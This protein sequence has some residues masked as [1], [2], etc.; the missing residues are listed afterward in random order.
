MVKEKPIHIGIVYITTGIYSELWKEFYPTCECYFCPDTQKGYEVFTDSVR[1]QEMELKNVTWHP[2]KD[3]GFIRNVSAKAEFICSISA[4]LKEKYDYVFYLNGNYKFLEPIYSDEILPEA[5]HHYL[6]ALSFDTYKNKALSDLP[7]DRNPAC[8]AYIERGQGKKYYQ[9]GFY[10]GRTAEVIELSEWCMQAIRKDLENK[11]IARWHDES[12]LNRYLRDYTPRTLNDAYGYTSF[13]QSPCSY[14][15]ILIEKS[16]YL[17]DK[18][19][20]TKDL[21]VDNSL[22]FLMDAELRPQKI[23]VVRFDGGLGNQMF[24]YAYY[25]Y[26]RKELGQS[27]DFYIDRNGHT[28]LFDTFV[29]PDAIVLSDELKEQINQANPCQKQCYIEENASCFQPVVPSGTAITEYIGYWQCAAYAY[30]NRETLRKAFRFEKK[31]PGPTSL[32][33]LDRIKSTNSV[34]IH[35]RRGDYQ[36]PVNKEVYGCICTMD[37]YT[38]AIRKMKNLLPEKPFF[39]LFTDDPEWVKK[40]FQGNDYFLVEGN[41]GEDDWQDLLLMSACRH[42]I[43]AN[44]SFSWWAAWLNE[45]PDKKVLAPQWWYYGLPTPDLLPPSWIRIPVRT[46]DIKGWL[47]AH[48]FMGKMQTDPTMPYWREMALAV[49]YFYLAR[50]ARK[51]IY[52]RLA[53]SKL[54]YV[55][56]RLGN[57]RTTEELIKIS[58]SLVYLHNQH[59]IDGNPDNIFADIDAALQQRIAGD[60]SRSVSRLIAMA[61]YFVS[62]L[63]ASGEEAAKG[64]SG[65]PET[66]EKIMN[67]LWSG[68]DTLSLRD[69]EKILSLFR[70]LNEKQMLPVNRNALFMYC[71]RE[72]DVS[73]LFLPESPVL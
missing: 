59:Y 24:Q 46:P 55:C 49:Y 64:K 28:Q 35:I 19:N 17:G 56:R 9:G 34:S 73:N 14:K 10:G 51:R 69:K 61:G 21:S 47:S 18:L 50:H 16:T 6:T 52:A 2:V 13:F 39:Y 3:R 45:N 41:R 12:Y 60:D 40:H 31:T 30:T 38:K 63:P 32:L 70:I 62:R 22:S 11:I 33:L 37:Y 66:L 54:D 71:I 72:Y 1:L 8:R 20:E 67:L 57:I 25:Q 58:H 65:L 36:N 48:L 15:A 27:I 42:H 26:L 44:S 4:A 5:E 7:Y 23:G 53:E 43:L 68:R 29:L